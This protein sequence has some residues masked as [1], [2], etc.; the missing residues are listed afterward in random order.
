MFSLGRTSTYWDPEVCASRNFLVIF[1]VVLQDSTKMFL[2]C[3]DLK[4]TVL[5]QIIL[6]TRKSS[7]KWPTGVETLP[8][9]NTK[10]GDIQFTGCTS[11]AEK[12]L[13]WLQ[14]IKSTGLTLNTLQVSS[15]VDQITWSGIIYSKIRSSYILYNPRYG[16]FSFKNTTRYK[17]QNKNNEKMIKKK[18]EKKE[19][20][21][22]SLTEE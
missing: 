14:Y 12:W 11:R 22:R 10:W 17:A 1:H 9:I 16:T 19:R 20:R 2:G 5:K 4:I 18:G 13:N 3:R 15:N 8:Y 21:R 6:L 7:M